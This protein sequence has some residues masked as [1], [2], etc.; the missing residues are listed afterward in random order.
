MNSVMNGVNIIKVRDAVCIHTWLWYSTEW[1][2]LRIFHIHLGGSICIHCNF[3]LKLIVFCLFYIV[4]SR[5]IEIPWLILLN[6][7]KGYFFCVKNNKMY[8]IVIFISFAFN[9]PFKTVKHNILE[10]P[11][12]RQNRHLNKSYCNE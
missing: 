11:N 8:L 6:V 12:E 1:K 10:I 9:R 2:L 7:L 4:T 5:S 3:N